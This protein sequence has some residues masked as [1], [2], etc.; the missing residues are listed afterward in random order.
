[1]FDFGAVPPGTQRPEAQL[2]RRCSRYSVSP[3]DVFGTHCAECLAGMRAEIEAEFGTHGPVQVVLANHRAFS[4]WLR[5]RD[6]R[7]P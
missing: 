5:I 6:A 3:D 1:M 2:C 7:R 4:E